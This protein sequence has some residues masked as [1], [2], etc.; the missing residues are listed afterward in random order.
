MLFY[1]AVIVSTPTPHPIISCPE[2]VAT[3]LNCWCLV[4]VCLCV[5]EQERG[6]S[7]S[8]VFKLFI[9]FLSYDF[10]LELTKLQS[11]LFKLNLGWVLLTSG[12]V[13]GK[14]G[15]RWETELKRFTVWCFV[16]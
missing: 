5:T 9:A 3:K 6:T 1:R 13:G 7:L 2:K 11:R 16:L 8:F 12:E 15:E 10:H 4:Y 14:E